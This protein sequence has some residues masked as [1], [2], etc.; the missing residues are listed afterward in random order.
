[1]IIAAGFVLTRMIVRPV[2]RLANLTEELSPGS[3]KKASLDADEITALT[4]AVS[5]I[6][7]ELREK[8]QAL[9]GDVELR[10]QAMQKLSR[11]LQE[12]AT[13][14]ETAINS[15]DLPI[16]LFE[17]GG[18]ILQVNQR[19]SQFLG[20]AADRLKSM[21]LLAVVAELRRHVVS[22][23]K[24]TSE[25]EA[26]FR[27]P[28]AARDATIPLKDG[29]GSVRVYCVPVFGNLSSLIG[30]IIST[31]DSAAATEVD[32]LK[33][34]FISTVSHELRT[35]L[36]AIKGAVGLV[37][38]GAGGPVPG[39]IR[40]LLEIAGSNTDRL[41][42]LVN[43][44]LEIFRMETGK[45]QLRPASAS[46]SELIAK[47]CGASQA[48]AAG[49]S[50]RLETRIAAHLPLAN[51]DAEQVQRVLEKLISNAVKFSD[52]SSVVRVG[53]EPMPDNS[54]FILVWVQDHGHGIPLEAQERIFEKFEQAEAVATR[55]HQGSG[56]G[57]AICRGVVEGHGGRIWV[58]SEPRKGSTFYLTLPVA[59][60]SAARQAVSAQPAAALVPAPAPPRAAAPA[61][62]GP[63]TRK[64]VMVV[65]DDPDTRNVISR[66]LQ[67]VGHFVLEV[68]T[69]SQVADLAVRHQPD[70][71]ALDLLLPDI[72]GLEVLRNLKG[73]EKTRR[74]PVLCLSVS[75]DFAPQALAG[76]AVQ[77]LRKPLDTAAL[78]RS[79]HSATSASVGQKN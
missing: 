43:D 38:G 44:I 76:G 36:T 46:I 48:E 24:L 11:N 9:T 41:I 32:H 77:F 79:I 7:S 13:S 64:L 60:P 25:A 10:N 14:F 29:R 59:Q 31:A 2:T 57:L 27:K 37:L 26:I 75:E 47:A 18:G 49:A 34:E 66:M 74:I 56:L 63:A 50:I 21:G 68:S 58:K 71:I 6:T 42:Q 1:L 54:K 62:A 55:Q 35:P 73:S 70:V 78:M 19:F 53:A 67:S 28:S 33:S 72:N 5:S 61:A 15:M 45:L 3:L 40:D 17:A 23:D 51:V 30:I 52:P 12:Q 16:C 20:V 4:E 8:E 39:P 69:G 22:A 65:E